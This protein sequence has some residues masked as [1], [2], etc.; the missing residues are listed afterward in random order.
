MAPPPPPHPPTVERMSTPDTWTYD[1][2]RSR[3]SVPAWLPSHR[4][5]AE[6]DHLQS[7][8][9]GMSMVTGN[10]GGLGGWIAP[11]PP[12][13]HSRH[14]SYLD[15]VIRSFV[16]A[17]K[18]G[19]VQWRHTAGV[20]GRQ[21]S[22]SFEG[23]NTE[24]KE[25]TEEQM[26]LKRQAD[27][28]HSERWE[29]EGM[30]GSL[31]TAVSNL[32]YAG[33]Q[34]ARLLLPRA[35]LWDGSDGGK[36]IPSVPLPDM[37]KML[38]LM[39]P[40]PE[41]C[42]VYVDPETFEH[43]GI[44]LYEEDNDRRVELTW[45]DRSTGFTHIRQT[46]AEGALIEVAY[47]F[48]GLMPIFEMVRKPLI[49]PQIIQNQKAL[50]LAL[51]SVPRNVWSAGARARTAFNVEP[52]PEGEDLDW[53]AATI[54]FLEGKPIVDKDTGKVTGYATPSMQVEEP[55]DVG[56]SRE[57]VEIH[58]LQILKEARQLHAAMGADAVASAIS[59]IV[60]RV[61]FLGSLG[62][63]KPT[64][65]ACIEWQM[66]CRM[67]MAEAFTGGGPNRRAPHPYTALLRADAE[68]K[69]D[70]GPITPE[71][72]KALDEMVQS[73]RLSDETAMALMGVEDVAE[74]KARKDRENK[75]KRVFELI[76]HADNAGM[77][78]YA[79]LT[80]LGG[81]EPEEA[82]ALAR[83]DVTAGLTQ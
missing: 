6:G 74:E 11:M 23:K 80:V 66:N 41:T 33:R 60:A 58:E 47:D 4:A 73:G 31:Q 5:F 16:S 46:N 24:Q 54:N 1:D 27:A 3:V 29:T 65:D 62:E 67:A 30:H 7:G 13:G 69:L 48:G 50:N 68:C 37:L 53:G 78:R 2:S 63:T 57:A 14:K 20:V 28:W 81:L 42:S 10:P 83:G 18:V 56:P 15:G 70:P 61:E 52:P 22:R 51:T 82:R 9:L 55:V 43:V 8:T 59:R 34:P 35:F 36:V 75:T 76:E 21:P 44:Y 71:E 49:T 64:A 12:A 79:V 77:D 32:L 45:V 72:R 38:R 26:R 19:E 17:N 40:A 39:Y 25:L